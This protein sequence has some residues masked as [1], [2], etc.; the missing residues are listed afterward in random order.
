MIYRTRGTERARSD[1]ASL[2]AVIHGIKER[3]EARAHEAC[4]VTA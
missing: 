3:A 2:K 1:A 4:V